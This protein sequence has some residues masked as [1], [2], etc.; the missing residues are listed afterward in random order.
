MGDLIVGQPHAPLFVER[1][2]PRLR[3]D[4]GGLRRVILAEEGIKLPQPLIR[5]GKHGVAE[6][7]QGGMSHGLDAVE[8]A[9]LLA[10]QHV[11][12]NRRDADA[13]FSV[14]LVHRL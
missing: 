11:A 14:Q 13:P 6:P 9:G 4:G 8:A 10:G 3:E 5:F 1:K 2:Q 7:I 12:E